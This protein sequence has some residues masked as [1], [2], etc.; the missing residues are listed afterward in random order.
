MK[1]IQISFTLSSGGAER[2]VVDL[3]NELNKNP[4]NQLIVLTTLDDSNPANRH[5]LSSLSSNIKYLNIKSRKSY[6]IKTLLEIY[7]IIKKEKPDIVHAH[8]HCLMIYLP[9]ILYRKC[10]YIKTLHSLANKCQTF[11]IEKYIN[12]FYFKYFITP[13]TIS[14]VCFQSYVNFY[15]K[16]NAININNGRSSQQTTSQ[17]SIVKEEIENLKTSN[18]DKVFIHVARCHPAK[19]QSLLFNSFIKLA[20]TYNNFQLIIIGNGFENSEFWHYRNYKFIHFLGEKTN[21]ADYLACADFFV[22]TSIFEGLPLSLLEAMSMKVIP[23]CTPAGGVVDV[24]TDGVNGYLSN[25]IEIKDFLN[26]I[27]RALQ[28]NQE[29]IKNKVANDYEQNYSMHICAEKYYQ[30]YQNKITIPTKNIS[31]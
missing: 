3:S 4:D 22:L 25:S 9:A 31:K 8:C 10:K 11:K 20:E 17:Y 30:L 15:K 5:Y 28:G 1:I 12:K 16:N 26:T 7:R 21:V 24:I 27:K 19:N 18:N 29:V 2:F 6:S 14:N 23:I 13:V